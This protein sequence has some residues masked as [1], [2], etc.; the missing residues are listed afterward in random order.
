MS[1]LEPYEETEITAVG[2]GTLV[3]FW[4]LSPARCGALSGLPAFS[5]P[6]VKQC[7]WTSPPTPP[8]P[9]PS[10]TKILWSHQV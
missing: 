3:S 10:R 1:N 4:T 5:E 2:P 7:G 9:V 6:S 8:T